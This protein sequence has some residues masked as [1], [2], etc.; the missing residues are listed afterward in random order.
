MVEPN[1][2]YHLFIS[3]AEPSGDRHCA[4]LIKALR[5]L[6]PDIE[7]TGI[8]GPKM[9][10]VG[11]RLLENTADNASM[12]YNAVTEVMHYWKLLQRIK[13]HFKEHTVDLVIVCDSPSFNFH[14]A[15]A[16]KR[17]GISTL[18]YV[19]P[20][21]WAWAAWRIKKLRRTCDKLCCILPFE[22]TWFTARG[23]DA[24]FV[25]NPLLDDITEDLTP[26]VRDYARFD[27]THVK[28]ALM[29]GSRPAEIA[30]LWEPMQ[31]IALRLKT[32][33]PQATFTAVAANAE[34]QQTLQSS[35]LPGFECTYRVDTV[36]ETAINV[37]FC[38][39]ASGS[40]TLEVATTGCPMVIMYQSSRLAWKL[41]GWWL[42][43]SKYLSLVNLLADREL[44]PE[45]M[46]Y[47]TSIDPIVDATQTLIQNPR[48]LARIS[49]ELIR[50]TQP[51][52]QKNTA[53]EVARI[54]MEML[55]KSRRVEY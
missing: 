43:K 9:A 5:Q 35:Q 24:V 28:L 26:N 51:L 21:L 2:R 46:P 22:E 15:K 49:H 52:A 33:F 40:A 13:R 42:V 14:V 48:D 32:I 31:Q 54:A 23:I 19:A 4:N 55:N 6:N 36:R 20:Q 18:F 16:A 53:N 29:P 17:G 27:P 39:V 11:C 50:I 30:T 34:R 37:D 25:S 12:L 7:C 1:K 3:A 41:A 45:F 38:L 10:A 8:G 47:F 44:A